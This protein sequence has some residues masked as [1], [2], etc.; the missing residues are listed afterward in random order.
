[1]R[2]AV[3]LSCGNPPDLRT[4]PA[5]EVAEGESLV[6]VTAAPITPLDVLCASGT[7]YFGQPALPYIPGVQGVGKLTDG[8]RVWFP[9]QAGMRPGDGSFADLCAVPTTDLVPIPDGTRDETAAALGLS[10]VAAWMALTWRAALRPGEQVLVLGAG[11][12]VGQVAVQAARLLGARRVVAVCRSP[13]SQALATKNGADAVVPLHPDDTPDTLTP[14]LR[15]ALDGLADVV[16]D[17][18]FGIPATAAAQVLALGARIVNLGSAAAES[19]TFTS[20]TLRGNT[21]SLL[22]YTNNALTPTQRH[23]ALTEI[24]NH[25]ATGALSV[26]HTLTPLADIA[27]AWTSQATGTTPRRIVVQ[28]SDVPTPPS[29]P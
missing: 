16:I 21:A 23:T 13:H 8:T 17:P 25:A 4:V 27:P 28:L 29:V 22:G 6:Q 18:V 2:A 12:T 15:Q 5:P 9:T 14:R 26:D 20:A 1:M 7:S 10:A 19:A 3:V 11:G 24:F